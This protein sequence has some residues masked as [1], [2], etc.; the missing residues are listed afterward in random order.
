[1]LA[2]AVLIIFA[3]AHAQSFDCNKASTQVEHTICS[4][5]TLG[6]LDTTLASQLKDSV[7][8]ANPEQRGDYIRDERQWLRFR[9]QHCAPG[10]PTAGESLSECLAAAY[11]DRITSLKSL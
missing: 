4:N 7:S 9:N 8:N 10:S 6:E 3:Q 5:K 11:R 1:M 2:C